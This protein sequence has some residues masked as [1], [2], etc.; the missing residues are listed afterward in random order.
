[1]TER[2]ADFAATTHILCC[3]CGIYFSAAASSE[4]DQGNMNLASNTAPVPST[5]PSRVAA[6][7]RSAGCLTCRCTSV[8]TCLVVGLI[9]AP[10]QLLSDHAKLN[11]E[12]PR[13][14]LRLD[15]TP[16]LLPQP[17]QG[18]LIA[19]H[20]DPG[21]GPADEGAAVRLAT[22]HFSHT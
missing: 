2:A 19:S 18:G 4:N 16:L 22:A 10:V 1:M 8:I 13:E 20:D 6:I 9:P 7:H 11:K 17:H 3:S 12:V 14:I 21:V 15:I 5:R